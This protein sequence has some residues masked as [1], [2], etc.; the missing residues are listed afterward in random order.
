MKK[1]FFS[2]SPIL[3]DLALLVM[4]VGVSLMMLTHGWPKIAEFSSRLATFR[5]PIG[6][7]PAVSL[8]ATI[9][10]EFF[11]S[12]L[13]ALG[14]MSRLA[15]IPLIFTMTVVTFI[16]H[17]EDP[18]STQEKPLLFLLI[19]VALFLLGPGKYSVDGQIK[20]NRNY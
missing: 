1:L 9:F 18:F 3:S 10:A 12:I 8:Q 2:T 19:Y 17:G 13:L 16:V 4:R 5:D 14:F 7:G 20:K 15:L 11:C 6:L